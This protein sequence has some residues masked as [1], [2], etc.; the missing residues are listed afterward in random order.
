MRLGFDDFDDNEE[1]WLLDTVRQAK[2]FKEFYCRDGD[3]RHIYCHFLQFC[4]FVVNN[5]SVKNTVLFWQC[6]QLVLE[7]PRDGRR[8]VF[9]L[10]DRLIRDKE[11]DGLTEIPVKPDTDVHQLN[12]DSDEADGQPSVEEKSS[13]LPCWSIN[14]THD[15]NTF[16]SW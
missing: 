11:L 2:C 16:I 15:I 14:F 1:N 13:R 6:I 12:R 4:Y 9:E 10:N 3:V 5:L 7:C 8:Y